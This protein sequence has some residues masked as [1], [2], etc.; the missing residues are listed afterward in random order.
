[1]STL[2]PGHV[3]NQICLLDN[4]V[5]LYEARTHAYSVQ[6]FQAG[7]VVVYMTYWVWSAMQSTP[8]SPGF[9]ELY[10]I[11]E[12]TDLVCYMPR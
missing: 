6:L 10:F 7:L 11:V 4:E 1:M 2:L 12:E 8:E 5:Q 3:A 9:V